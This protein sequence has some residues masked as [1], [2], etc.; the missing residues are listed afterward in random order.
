MPPLYFS[1]LIFISFIPL[2][3]S[4]NSISRLPVLSDRIKKASVSGL[5]FSLVFIGFS[6]LWIL[7]LTPYSTVINIIILFFIFTL[8]QSLFYILCTVLFCAF[9]MPLIAFPFLWV[10]CEWLRGCGPFASTHYVVGYSQALQG[11]LLQYA[12]IG[13]VYFVSLLCLLINVGLF[14]WLRSRLKFNSIRTLKKQHLLFPGVCILIIGINLALYHVYPSNQVSESIK[15]GL[16]QANHSQKDKLNRAKRR[17]LLQD[18]YLY[19]NRILTKNKLD[20][21]IFPETIIP[22]YVLD[23]AY[24]MAQLKQLSLTH[25]NSF[26]FGTARSENNNLFNSVALYDS[27]DNMQIYDK[28]RRMPFG[29]YWPFKSIFTFF[30]LG[31]IIPGRDYTMGAAIKPLLFKEHK[32]GL[33]ICL[34]SMYPSFYRE[35]VH[36]G[37][38][39]LIALANSAWFHESW[40]SA[41]LFHMGVFRA[42]ENGRYFIQSSNIGLSGIISERGDIIQVS[43]LNQQESLIYDLKADQRDTLFGRFGNWVIGLCFFALFYLLIKKN[44][45]LY[46]RL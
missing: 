16:V 6:N 26:L 40:I 21:L 38:D 44:P 9:Q 3:I 11:P 15:L 43:Q 18:Y 36:Q 39:V 14:I 25:N 46:Q 22:S 24:F 4:L 12:S 28:V 30:G 29:E 35:Q 23:K 7:E 31:N 41:S 2:F 17:L 10:I 33:G 42:V 13:G 45:S 19:S 32:L 5:V 34:E 8:F 1:W 27:S 37:A 20:L